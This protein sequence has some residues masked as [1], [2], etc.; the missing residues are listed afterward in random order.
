MSL[1]VRDLPREGRL[2]KAETDRRSAEAR[3][4]YWEAER[5]RRETARREV[6]RLARQEIGLLTDREVLIAGAVA[7]WCEGS[8]NKP[9][10][11]SNHI[12]F[13][14]SDPGLI[15]LFLRFMRVVGVSSARLYFRVHIHENA[16]VEAA[17]RYWLELTGA[18]PAQ[19][20]R[21]TL[22]R[23]NPKTVRRNTGE[24]Y[25]GCLRVDVRDPLEIYL[26]IEGWARG[27]MDDSCDPDRRP[28]LIA[29][30]LYR[31]QS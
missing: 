16:D 23:H 1:W 22:K 29:G 4:R 19:F 3:R 27:A 12:T 5:P 10:R 11:E 24:T 14:N 25:R 28:G 18:D 2:S 17:G 30:T 21:T 26:K 15:L 13:I 6:T 7:Y 31:G 9:H 8:K 20:R